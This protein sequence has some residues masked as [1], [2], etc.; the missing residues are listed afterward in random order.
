MLEQRRAF[1]PFVLDPKAGT[2]VRDGEPV[3][4]NFR[5][6][7]LLTA[8][9]AR[10]GEVLTK[11]DLL[12]AAWEGAIVDETNL[13]VQ[14]AALRK[15]L[16]QSPEGGDW[17]ATVPRVGYRFVGQVADPPDRSAQDITPSASRTAEGGPSIAVLPFVNLSDDREQEY[18]A[19]GMVEEIIIALSRMRWLFVIARNSS[20]TYKGRAI[21][22]KQVGRE[23][24]VRYVLEGSVRKAGNRVRITGQLIDASTG[25][26]LWADRFDGEL[27][28]IFDLQDQVTANV[29]SAIAPRLQDAEIERAKRKP[30]ESLDAYDYFLRGMAAYHQWTKSA[31]AE[32]SELFLKAVELDPNFAAAYAMASR[33]YAQRKSMGGLV[34]PRREMAECLRL[35]RRAVDLGRDDPVALCSAGSALAFGVGDLDLAATAIDRTLRLDP[36]MAWA[37]LSSSLVKTWL[38]EAEPAIE[39]AARAMRLSPYD[40]QFF[41]MQIA[42]AMAH[43][44]A[45]RYAE[46]QSWA[47]RSSL[48]HPDY[49]PAAAV[50]A[51]SAAL[52]GNLV[53]AKEA[54]ERLRRLVPALRISNLGE[55]LFPFRRADDFNRMSE[56]LRKAGLPE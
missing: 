24:G 42:T 23:L 39:H 47:E 16:G 26:H 21:D 30:T 33:C 29:A 55:L 2:L 7:L 44:V 53:A 43:F 40:T 8:F 12:A 1:G 54:M 25:V 19:D 36:N 56:A 37:W 18:F 20:F 49:V 10:P 48:A 14:I 27:E 46:A 4:V 6:L 35:A 5:G 50:V 41:V 11:S 15:Q 13:S 9:L 28:N 51:A 32:A 34:E 52:D 17:I 22:V 38:G 3:S 31:N 45:G